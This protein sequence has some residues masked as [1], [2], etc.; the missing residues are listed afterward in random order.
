MAIRKHK[1]GYDVYGYGQGD[2]VLYNL[3][4]YELNSLLVDISCQNINDEF[5][6]FGEALNKL[7]ETMK[8]VHGV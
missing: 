7:D 4:K 5:G 8:E 3:S 6:I 2:N 1:H